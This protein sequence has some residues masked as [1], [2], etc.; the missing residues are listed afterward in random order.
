MS[1]FLPR[2][3]G[4]IRLRADAATRLECKWIRARTLLTALGNNSYHSDPVNDIFF[5]FL[6]CERKVHEI[7]ISASGCSAVRFRSYS[8]IALKFI[9]E[10]WT[11]KKKRFGSR[12]NASF[13]STIII[14]RSGF[15]EAKMLTDE[16]FTNRIRF[17]CTKYTIFPCA[18]ANRNRF[19]I[20]ISSQPLF[21]GIDENVANWEKKTEREREKKLP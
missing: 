4:R 17:C 6:R 11:W 5:L 12:S 21:N 16:H 9:H 19:P 18:C 8:E 1:T 20:H 10:K 7:H 13:A 15:Y 14:G 3:C 2:V